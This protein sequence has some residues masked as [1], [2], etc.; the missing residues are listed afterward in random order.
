MSGLELLE[1]IK[2]EPRLEPIPVIMIS[3][4]STE[5][6]GVQATKLGAQAYMQKPLSVEHFDEVVG[7]LPWAT[8]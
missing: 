8:A 5:T 1:T 3:S 2:Q 6:A 4:R 7:N